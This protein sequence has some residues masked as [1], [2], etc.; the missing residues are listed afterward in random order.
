VAMQA[1]TST[2][3]R[4]R[5][6]VR[7][8]RLLDTA[9]RLV[10]VPSW[11]G[12]AG[13]AADCLAEILRAD[14]FT[15]ERP[16]AGHA[17]APAVV[18]RLTSGKPGSTLQLDG[19]VDTVH[20]PFVPPAVTGDRL[21]G[22]GSYDMKSGVAA[23][24]E[25]LRALRETGVLAAGSVL[26]TAHD[27][28][29]APWGLGQQ[30]DR[31]I[32]DGIVGDAA[33]VCEPIATHV[34]IAGRGAATWKVS[35]RRPGPPIHEVMR[36][37]GEPSVIAAGAKLV[38][39]LTHLADELA[40]QADPVAGSASV[41]VGQIHSGEIYNQYP[42]ECW[43]EGTRR[44]LPGTDR[45]RVE[46]EFRDL[47]DGVAA[48]TGTTVTVDYRNIRDAFALDP[49][50][51]VFAA[52]QEA[53]AAVHGSPLPTGPK[54]FVDDGN[55]FYGLKRIPAITHGGVGGGAHTLGEWVSV[56]SLVEAALTYALTAV[57]YC[58]ASES[59]G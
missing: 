37:A 58:G 48:E 21:T 18:V 1:S 12:E 19:H 27:L 42:Q 46:S 36:P 25:A 59:R 10:A 29:E 45:S 56:D 17:T 26:F 24:V 33:V 34:P 14:G 7:R 3:D 44:W 31:M 55:S 5:Q 9:L 30:L 50:E 2:V 13:A 52:F 15:V 23:A 35:I 53:H 54:P 8:D 22:S 20:L 43:L 28:H 49:S 6:A 4:L 47:L 51:A 32:L 57:Y 41:F 11:T 39:H 16:E 38:L 40:H